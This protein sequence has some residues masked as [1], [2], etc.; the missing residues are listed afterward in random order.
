MVDL[1]L[2]VGARLNEGCGTQDEAYPWV[3]QHL[4]LLVQKLGTISVWH[5]FQHHL[6][7]AENVS[8]RGS[9]L[10]ILCGGDSIPVA[11]R[12]VSSLHLHYANCA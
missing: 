12:L 9:L 8:R 3:L 7:A 1:L 5:R 11:G 4:E 2:P 10:F 6:K